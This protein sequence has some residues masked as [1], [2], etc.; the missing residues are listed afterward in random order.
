MIAFRCRAVATATRI[1]APSAGRAQ[2]TAF[3][4]TDEPKRQSA[5]DQLPH[6]IADIEVGAAQDIIFAERIVRRT[7]RIEPLV[8]VDL[9]RNR[10]VLETPDAF[11]RD[12][13]RDQPVDLDPAIDP[14]QPELG[15]G[16]AREPKLCEGGNRDGFVH[17]HR[18]TSCKKGTDVDD[19]VRTRTIE[20]G[21]PRGKPHANHGIVDGPPPL[22]KHVRARERGA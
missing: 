4:T 3:L 13:D 11:S 2:P 21:F 16:R 17:R 14:L 20:R 15:M 8:D 10:Y 5:G 7:G 1:F 18:A 12:V 22:V 19:H 9:D 6:E